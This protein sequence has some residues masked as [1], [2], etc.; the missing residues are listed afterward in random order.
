MD[1]SDMNVEVESILSEHEC[2]EKQML[3]HQNCSKQDK[4]KE[5]NFRTRF[6]KIK[7]RPVFIRE[8]GTVVLIIC[9]TLIATSLCVQGVYMM[10]K[11]I[12]HSNEYLM[13]AVL[14]FI[15]PIIDWFADVKIGRYRVMEITLFLL[16]ISIIL[17]IINFILA[18][19]DTGSSQLSIL[20][21]FDCYLIS[22]PLL[23][24]IIFPTIH[25]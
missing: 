2:N 19:F 9:N 21:Y 7:Y 1:R 6:L 24:H 20:F 5:H 12:Y 13:G 18:Q 22:C 16:G 11:Y 4:A 3:L 15:F 8:I 23:L 17:Q 14:I 25:H 10:N